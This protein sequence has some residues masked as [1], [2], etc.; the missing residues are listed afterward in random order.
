MSATKEIDEQQKDARKS[1]RGAAFGQGTKRR[2]SKMRRRGSQARQDPGKT[3]KQGNERRASDC[4]TRASS[5]P[6][7]K[8]RLPCC[9]FGPLPVLASWVLGPWV[10]GCNLEERQGGRGIRRTDWMLGVMPKCKENGR[11]PSAISSRNAAGSTAF[12]VRL[13][14]RLAQKGELGDVCHASAVFC[15]FLLWLEWTRKARQGAGFLGHRLGAPF[16]FPPGAIDVGRDTR[17]KIPRIADSGRGIEIAGRWG[18]RHVVERNRRT[19]FSVSDA[20]AVHI[21]SELTGNPLFLGQGWMRR[22]AQ[23]TSAVRIE[24]EKRGWEEKG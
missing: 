8:G 16:A 2:P 19:G 6:D 11:W 22:P 17:Y 15:D 18:L 5:M 3:S 13:L 23:S 7:E 4:Q 20:P 12:S 24:D 14:L 9:A 10:F 21:A 1:E